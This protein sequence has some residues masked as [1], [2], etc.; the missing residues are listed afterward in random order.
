MDAVQHHEE[1]RRT[2][3]REMHA[4]INNI[5]LE[6]N[7]VDVDRFLADCSL[8]WG[9]SDRTNKEYLKVVLIARGLEVARTGGKKVIKIPEAFHQSEEAKAADDKH[10]RLQAKNKQDK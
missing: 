2:R 6:F 9:T 10:T 4:A 7:D 1:I 8:K 3:L 5:F